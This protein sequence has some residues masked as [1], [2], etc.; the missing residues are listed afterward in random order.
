MKENWADC[1]NILIIRADNM[2][3][4]LMSSPAIRAVKQTLGC[5]ITVLTSS[6][7]KAIVPFIPEI[8]QVIVCDLP[9]IKHSNEFNAGDYEKLIETL[10]AAK[11]DGAI[12]FTVYSQ[13]Q[14]PSAMLAYLAGIPRRLAYCREN[15]YHLLT[16][17]A[18]EKEPYTFVRHQVR[19]D[20]DLV[21]QI[22]CLPGDEHLSLD[23]SRTCWPQLQ[24]KLQ[25]MNIPKDRWWIV[26]HAGV[27]EAKRRYPVKCWIEAGKLL[28]N[29][30]PCRLLFTGSLTEAG[31]SEKICEE[32]GEE[33]VSLSGKLS[34]Q[35]FITLVK[36]TELVISV[37]TSTI[38][39]A[40]AS[41][42]PIIVLYAL[43]NP[44]HTPW[45]A[46]GEVLPF[47]VPEKLRSKN[48][49]IKFVN[50]HLFVGNVP[51]PDPADIC[52]AAG[53]ILV[54]G[55]KEAIPEIILSTRAEV[56]KIGK[57]AWLPAEGHL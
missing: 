3:D 18:A 54:E 9:W 12:I 51:V 42:V 28:L 57:F 19:R 16:D 26:M 56:K 39:I 11:Y 29:A 15:P 21:A 22:Q 24:T 4:V 43:T 13:N 36:H 55:K 44:Q 37:N 8:D 23:T 53:R 5:K 48:E 34:L 31:T 38:H 32:I 1:K 45:K 52:R 30:F 17:W 49:V 33:S 46:V 10:K 14:L 27:S 50:D 6:M 41:R 40:A 7:G 20:L 2:G 35:E 47:H 25:E